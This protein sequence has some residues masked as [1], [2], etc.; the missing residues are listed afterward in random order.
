MSSKEELYQQLI[1]EHNK[2]P[3]NFGRL[4]NPTHVAEGFNPLCGDHYHVFLRVNEAGIIEE[5]SFD[6]SGCAISKASASM[7]T[8]SLKG[9]TEAQAR[10]LFDAFHELITGEMEAGNGAV[11]LG[12]LAAFSG[13]WKFPARIKCAVLCW[14]TINGALEGSQ[15]ALTTE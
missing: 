4:E 3:R 7:M 9:K 10:G 5:I 1:L 6:G 14:H 12:K 11:K 2:K 13:V 15:D 8:Q